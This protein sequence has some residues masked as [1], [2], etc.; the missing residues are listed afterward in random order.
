LGET[1]TAVRQWDRVG[2]LYLDSG[3]D[4]GAIRVL[5][6]IIALDP[7]DVDEYRRL[8]QELREKK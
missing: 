8:Y 1:E 6:A 7:P 3:D 2:E 5:N 4:A